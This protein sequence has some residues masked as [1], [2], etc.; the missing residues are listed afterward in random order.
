MKAWPWLIETGFQT[1]S[2]WFWRERL[3]LHQLTACVS[4]KWLLILNPGIIFAFSSVK[5][6][7]TLGKRTKIVCVKKPFVHK[8]IPDHFLQTEKENVEENEKQLLI[9]ISFYWETVGY[10]QK[11]HVRI[12]KEIYWLQELTLMLQLYGVGFL[13]LSGRQENQSKSNC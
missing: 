13:Q 9:L 1:G 4:R 10:I 12:S 5:M 8:R 6:D 11:W 2:D 3:P 7:I